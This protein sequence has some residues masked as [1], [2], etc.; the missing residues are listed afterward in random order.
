MFPI[1]L[2][3]LLSHR[4]YPLLAGAFAKR[5]AARIGRKIAPLSPDDTR[6]LQA[7]AWPGNVRELENVIERAVITSQAGRL[8]LDRALPVTTTHAAP[9]AHATSTQPQIRTV[10]EMEELDR[11]NIRRALDGANWRVAGDNGAASLL[12]MNLLR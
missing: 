5:F 8:N 12:G 2:P 4:R 10:R 11:E 9:P 3:P 7:C 6:R 1:K